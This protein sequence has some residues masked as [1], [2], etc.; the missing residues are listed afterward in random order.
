MRQSHLSSNQ[1]F[2]ESFRAPGQGRLGSG[3]K[4]FE[5]EFASVPKDVYV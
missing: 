3:L 4:G 1:K 5:S 2:I